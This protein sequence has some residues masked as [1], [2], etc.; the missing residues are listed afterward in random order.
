MLPSERKRSGQLEIEGNKP[1]Q[2]SAL[3][4]EVLTIAL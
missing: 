1:Y 4:K 2:Q 3:M